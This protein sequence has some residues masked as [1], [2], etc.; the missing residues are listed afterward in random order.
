VNIYQFSAFVNVLYSLWFSLSL[1]LGPNI[2]FKRHPR[3]TRVTSTAIQDISQGNNSGKLFKLKAMLVL[4]YSSYARVH[5][6]T[7]AVPECVQLYRG[8]IPKGDRVLSYNII[9]VPNPH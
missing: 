9:V 3:V 5:G 2:I 1:H 8:F 7:M 4:V 6:R